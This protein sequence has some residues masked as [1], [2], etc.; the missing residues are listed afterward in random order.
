MKISEIK[1]RQ[2]F[3]A[4]HHIFGFEVVKYRIQDYLYKSKRS[5]YRYM[6][7]LNDEYYF[8]MMEG[9]I[10]VGFINIIHNKLTK[11]DYVILTLDEYENELNGASRNKYYIITD[12]ETIKPNIKTNEDVQMY[13]KGFDSST[14]TYQ[15]IVEWC[16]QLNILIPNHSEDV[17]QIIQTTIKRNHRL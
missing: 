12:I 15:A 16:I 8:C 5:N 10:Y 7:K 4:I 3:S 11:E 9:P 17:T 1:Q 13:M 14:I 6:C 2:L